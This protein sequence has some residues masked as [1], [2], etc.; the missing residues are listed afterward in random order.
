ML[1]SGSFSV[2]KQVLESHEVIAAGTDD[3]KSLGKF[4]DIGIF[5]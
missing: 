3:L 4:E 2:R 5:F 1:K